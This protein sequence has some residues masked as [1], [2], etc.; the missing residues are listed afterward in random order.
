MSFLYLEVP[1]SH[2][3]IDT[4]PDFGLRVWREGSP[5]FERFVC[6]PCSLRHPPKFTGELDH[7]E[8][9]WLCAVGPQLT[10]KRV[11]CELIVHIKFFHLSLN[12]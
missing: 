1:L 3:N 2:L 6:P 8:S 4:F 9:M 7:G 11:M 5:K 10:N 12:M